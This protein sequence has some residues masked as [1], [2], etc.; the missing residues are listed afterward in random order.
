MPRD[1]S[2]RNRTYLCCVC[3]S[4]ARVLPRRRVSCLRAHVQRRRHGPCLQWLIHVMLPRH[5][6]YTASSVRVLTHGHAR[7]CALERTDT[8]CP[9]SS[10]RFCHG[11][12][13]LIQISPSK[14]LR[15]QIDFSISYDRT[16]YHVK[17]I[18]V[19]KKIAKLL[20][21]VSVSVW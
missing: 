6:H 19:W 7:M 17:I 13:F 4:R 3:I 11:W 18:I 8:G 10:S 12:Q 9:S 16:A 5:T 14:S 15:R 2:L 20:N 21:R 1:S